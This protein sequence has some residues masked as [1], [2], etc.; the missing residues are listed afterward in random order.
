[1]LKGGI[2]FDHYK[3]WERELL[4]KPKG[5]ICDIVPVPM[6]EKSFQK[7]VCEPLMRLIPGKGRHYG[8]SYRP[9]C[10]DGIM[11]IQ[12]YRHDDEVGYH[13]RALGENIACL[14]VQ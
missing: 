3:V 13:S 10:A 8:V 11:T 12:A 2:T 4:R 5:F 9:R 1:M 7:A 14:S 6:D